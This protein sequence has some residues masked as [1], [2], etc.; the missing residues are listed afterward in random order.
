MGPATHRTIL[1]D[2][3]AEDQ[4]RLFNQAWVAERGFLEATD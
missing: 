1:C 2:G 3:G 4:S